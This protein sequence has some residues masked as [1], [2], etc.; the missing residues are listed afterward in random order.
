MATQ[1]SK[2]LFIFDFQ[3]FGDASHMEDVK[4][5]SAIASQLP[6]KVLHRCILNSFWR[7]IGPGN[8]LFQLSCVL[9]T[10]PQ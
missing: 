10:V 4:V 6:V 3:T 2:S 5:C 9:S 1:T 8:N 7:V